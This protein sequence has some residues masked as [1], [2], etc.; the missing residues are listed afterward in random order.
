MNIHTE[1]KPCP[2]CKMIPQIRMTHECNADG[3]RFVYS[4]V[5]PECGRAGKGLPWK[6]AAIEE[7]NKEINKES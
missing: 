7:W 6:N 4:A 1:P 5:C 3:C 2:I